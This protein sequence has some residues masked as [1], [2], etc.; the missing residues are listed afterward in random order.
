VDA[1]LDDVNADKFGRLLRR[2]GEVS[3][4]LVI[5]HNKITMSYAEVLYGVT[6]PE[7]GVSTVLGVETAQA[8]QSVSAA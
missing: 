5:T 2:F 7:P 4:I 1:P 6:M 3:Q 8:L